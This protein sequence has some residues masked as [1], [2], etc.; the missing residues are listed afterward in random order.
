[1]AQKLAD[2]VGSANVLV[3]DDVRVGYEQDWTGRYEGRAV[4]VVR[5]GSTA[6]VVR[7]IAACAERGTPIVPQGGNTGLVGGGVPREHT[8]SGVGFGGADQVVLSTTR[9]DHLGSADCDSMQIT[10][11]AGVTLAGWRAAA[12]AAGLDTPVDFAARDSATIGGAISTNAG[13]SRV[14]RFGTMRHQVIGVEAVLANG[15]VVGSLDGLPKETAGLHWPSLMS[16][17]EGTFGIVT[18][19]RLRLV[20][21]YRSTATAMVATES[22]DSAIGLL[23][24]LRSSVE[25]LDAVEVIRSDAMAL[26]ADHLGVEPPVAVEPSHTVVIVECAAHDDPTDDLLAVLADAQEIGDTAVTTDPGPRQALLAFRDRITESIASAS[27]AIDVPTF[28]LDV[29]V[30]LSSL[31]ALLDVAEAAARR[32]GCRLIAFGHLAEGNLHLNHIGASDP[33]AIANEVLPAVAEMGGTISA[34]H[35]IGIAKAPWLHLIRSNADLAAQRSVKS[36]LDPLGI[37][38]PGVLAR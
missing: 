2:I 27:T 20:P 26:V 38:N 36:A 8:D 15:A 24:S 10:V 9:L 21:W 5:P 33:E 4:A 37:L 17:A 12:R 28:K 23:T 7:V 31:S 29:A 1:M 13:G 32:D 16:G 34:E 3:D 11:G 18:R 30:P 14:V 22:M 35:G 6:E 25:S 19:A